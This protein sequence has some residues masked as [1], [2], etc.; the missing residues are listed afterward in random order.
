M[1]NIQSERGQELLKAFIRKRTGDKGNEN[2]MKNKAFNESKKTC[3]SDREELLKVV[4]NGTEKLNI[5]EN[6]KSKS[7]RHSKKM[8]FCSPTTHEGS[9][10]CHLHRINATKSSTNEKNNNMKLKSNITNGVAEFKP[11]L[12]RFGRINS[13]EVGSHDSLIKLPHGVESD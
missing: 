7:N 2:V 6:N 3:T 13:S 9:F 11:Q 4:K 5:K 10:R 12:S 8:C 1:Q